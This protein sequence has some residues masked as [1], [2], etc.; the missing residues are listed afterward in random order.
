[1]R[2]DVG[3]VTDGLYRHGRWDAA[4]VHRLLAGC[5]PEYPWLRTDL[6]PPA[7]PDLVSRFEDL[8]G[9]DLPE[10]YRSFALNVG[11]GGAGPNYGLFTFDRSSIADTLPGTAW[12]AFLA[13]DPVGYGAP[14][15]HSAAWNPTELLEADEPV[16]AYY[17]AAATHGTWLLS[18]CG[19]AIWEFLVI[20][21]KARGEIWCDQ[22]TDGDGLY[23]LTR[24]PGPGRHTFDSWYSEW[25]RSYVDDQFQAVE[26]R[27]GSSVLRVPAWSARLVHNEIR[28]HDAERRF[29][30]AASE[31]TQL[32]DLDRLDPDAR[33]S[34]GSLLGTLAGELAGRTAMAEALHP[35]LTYATAARLLESLSDA[36][37]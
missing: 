12:S 27:V 34:L 25:L 8:H 37:R 18:D 31:S 21:G 23:P 29:L 10:A 19:C 11:A 26:L 9:V 17:S 13:E 4:L 15:E 1:M 5:Q 2:D 33:R 7:D 6:D 36:I 22:R 3:S 28:R 14:F 20:N 30:F 32:F 35:D 16:D 24:K